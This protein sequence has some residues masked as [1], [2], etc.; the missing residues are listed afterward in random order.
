[1]GRLARLK[2]DGAVLGLDKDIVAEG[3]FLRLEFV[4]GLLVAVGRVLSL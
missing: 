4:I 1:M 3:A 2:I